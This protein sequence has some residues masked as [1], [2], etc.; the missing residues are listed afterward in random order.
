MTHAIDGLAQAWWA[1]MWPMSWQV[2]V[3]V[4]L[5]FLA[6]VAIRRWAWPQV[7]AALWLL[8]LAKLAIPPSVASPVSVTSR[9]LAPA[10]AASGLAV[11]S[12][13]G[14]SPERL[15]PEAWAF[16]AWL[17]GVVVLA[18]ALVIRMRRLRARVLADARERAIPIEIGALLR[19]AAER[20]GLR[21][22]PLLA[23]TN[24]VRGPAILG[25][26][27]PVVL[28]PADGLP[29]LTRE[30]IEH[31]CLH[32]LAHLRRLDP[33]LH[34]A[35][36]ALQIAYWFNPL[37]WL[38]RRRLGALRELGCDATVADHLRQATSAYRD[39]LLKGA[40]R[41]I[42]ARVESGLAILGLF[43]GS[44]N[45]VAR[46]R[47]LEK[48]TWRFAPLRRLSSALV[49]AM[50]LGCVVPMGLPAAEVPDDVSAARPNP[51]ED[52]ARRVLES[53][54]A[55][56]RESCLRVHYAA[57]ALWGSGTTAGPD[58]PRRE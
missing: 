47:W 12:S 46:L 25:A 14:V 20:L 24:Q 5:A 22:V 40:R 17:A 30:E 42:D 4:A 53:A 50:M 7:R 52:A 51:E 3:L 31:I 16:L 27:R 21:R 44:A 55:G 48:D 45:I 28:L 34:A 29:G 35:S 15:T 8:V 2:A 36:L 56:N 32:E 57:L 39:T 26:L 23:L 9:L 13:P 54:L 6:D 19:R 18:T 10:P 58:A 11:L 1:W 37:V 38:V 49:A 43:G 33:Y 41:L